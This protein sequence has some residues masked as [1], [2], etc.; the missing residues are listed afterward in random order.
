MLK[1]C[2]SYSLIHQYALCV[3]MCLILLFSKSYSSEH[4]FN[5]KLQYV[6]QGFFAEH[7]KDYVKADDNI[8]WESECLISNTS[9]GVL[10]TMNKTYEIDDEDCLVVADLL[11]G[12]LLHFI[13]DD[14]FEEL[15]F[16]SFDNDKLYIADTYKVYVFKVKNRSG[17][18]IEFQ[19]I[20]DYKYSFVLPSEN[21]KQIGR[22]LFIP[23]SYPY[24]KYYDNPMFF[25]TL[26][27]DDKRTRETDL[28]LSKGFF[29]N[30]FLPRNTITASESF[31]ASCDNTEYNIYL[32][33][34]KGT[35][36]DTLKGD[37]AGK[38]FMTSEEIEQFEQSVDYLAQPNLTMTSVQEKLLFGKIH[39][40]KNI[41][42][43]DDNTILVCYTVPKNSTTE[44]FESMFDYNFNYDIWQN[45]NGKWQVL[46]ENK[47][48]INFDPEAEGKVSQNRI[49]IDA[50]YSIGKKYLL[51]INSI[52][53]I[54]D[55][56]ITY[57]EL[58]KRKEEFYMDNNDNGCYFIYT[59]KP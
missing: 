57:E 46:P 7:F 31:I 44:A 28:P 48:L 37:F 22:T 50:S 24:K 13:L 30:Y 40:L 18:K 17:N 9:V 8:D 39:I 42:F 10:A 45:I 55:K 14:D 41:N 25:C 26:D 20:N 33:D 36:L 23:Y 35:L 15:S 3:L 11:K 21:M 54:L 29:L 5:D 59:L 32:Y 58:K 53:F 4:Y 43:I 51:T 56:E 34:K 16:F 12:E 2:N 19:S 49:F 6:K 47:A 27:S 52:P 1:T 38:S